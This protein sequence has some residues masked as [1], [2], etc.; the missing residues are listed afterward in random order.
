MLGKEFQIIKSNF[1]LCRNQIETREEKH[2]NYVLENKGSLYFFPINNKNDTSHSLHVYHV[3]GTMLSSL[4]NLLF[5]ILY[6]ALN[7]IVIYYH[8]F[9]GENTEA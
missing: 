8:H 5:L 2:I 6:V 1:Y 9:T 7:F 3:P 4:H